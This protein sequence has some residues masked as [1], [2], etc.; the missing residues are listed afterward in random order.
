MTEEQI[1]DGFVRVMTK[2]FGFSNDPDNTT[3]MYETEPM[4]SN[5]SRILIMSHT[6]FVSTGND[7]FLVGTPYMAWNKSLYHI[8]FDVDLIPEDPEPFSFEV[9]IPVH[10]IIS[11]IPA[12][13]SP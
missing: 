11:I 9:W 13:K 4:A 10:E 1:F 2:G 6:K 7:T 5:D 12:P 3:L 8:A